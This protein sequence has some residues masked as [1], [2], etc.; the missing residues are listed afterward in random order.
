MEDTVIKAYHNFSYVLGAE[1]LYPDTDPGMTPFV[2]LY[3]YMYSLPLKH[4][5]LF[6]KKKHPPFVCPWPLSCWTAL[7]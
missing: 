5:C 1:S 3:K 2:E 7:P 4:T 6:E